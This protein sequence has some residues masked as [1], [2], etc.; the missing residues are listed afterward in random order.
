MKRMRMRCEKRRHEMSQ[1][2]LF[3]KERIIAIREEGEIAGAD[4]H[5]EFACKDKY[6]LI[7]I[8]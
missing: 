3:E 6:L 5:M 7:S 8:G 1:C 4:R 2:S